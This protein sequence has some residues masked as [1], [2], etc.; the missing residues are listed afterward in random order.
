M[1]EI[2]KEIYERP[3]RAIELLCKGCYNS[4]WILGKAGT[5][6]SYHTDQ[7][8]LEHKED[9]IIFTGDTS[10]CCLHAF[11]YKNRTKTIVF[12]DTAKLIRRLNF[13]DT[14]KNLTEMNKDRTISRLVKKQ[15][16]DTTPDTFVFEGK[17]IMEFNEIG[18]KYREDLEALFT[19]G[20]FVELT[21]SKEQMANV[22]LE[23]AKTELEKEVTRYLIANSYLLGHINFNLRTQ[24]KVLAVAKICLIEK[25]DWKE[26]LDM[27]FKSEMSEGKK[28][29][30]QFSGL[31]QAKRMEFIKYLIG[32]K[33][34]SLA[35]CQRRISEWLWLEEIYSNGLQKQ[36][37]LSIVPIKQKEEICQ[38]NQEI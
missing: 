4:V 7:T 6:K 26:D 14:L 31:K 21:L 1:S 35:T 27:L 12:R 29:L 37:M 5:G 9:S 34:W 23:I 19:R 2:I 17:I 15:T 3:I 13:I 32:T 10:E 28:L 36:A 30:Y 25:K 18:N 38:I 11:L 20:D 24:Q 8:L 33:R 22:M 16:D